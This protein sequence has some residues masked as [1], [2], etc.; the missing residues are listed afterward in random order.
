MPASMNRRQFLYTGAIAAAGALAGC[1][2]NPV[3]GQQ[4]LMLMSPQQEVEVDRQNAPHQ[5]SADYGK[6]DD[7]ALQTYVNSVG[8][9]MAKRTHRPDMPYNFNVVNAT[10]VNAYAFPGG[11]IAATRGIMLTLQNEAELGALMGHEMGHV[12]A[13]HTSSRMSKALVLQ[14]LAAGLAIGV[15]ASEYK[16]L[17]PL[18]AGLGAIG[19]GAL[20][21]HYSREDER[22]ADELGMEYMV[23]TG[24][25]P[26]GMVG[27]QQHLVDMHDRTPSAL[28]VLFS[29][30]PMSEERRDTAKY[31]AQTTYASASGLPLKRERYMDNTAKLRTLK[32]AI[33][34]M[35]TG[36]KFMSKKQYADA[37]VHFR[38]ALKLAPDDYVGLLLMSK[39][40]LAQGNKREGERYAELAKISKPG[41]AQALHVAGLAKL[42]MGRYDAALSQFT[43]YERALPGNPNTIYYEAMALDG[44]GQRD[45]AARQYSRYLRSGNR[46]ANAQRAYN[47]LQSWGYVK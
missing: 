44:M 34:E 47:R 26:Q 31:E 36:E 4:Q 38:K 37:E 45:Q 42:Q 33:D 23:K 25:S 3:T 18:A 21:A 15:S 1:A 40:Q 19:A 11:S 6:T 41:E 46:D 28:E 5:F 30:H 16:S 43:Q 14:G 17:T 29:S 35:Q 27:L 2:I 7:I 39:C 24:Y 32:P 9:D 22:Q 12:N 8:K 13:R 20:L 10:Y